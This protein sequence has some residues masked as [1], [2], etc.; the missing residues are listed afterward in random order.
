[1]RLYKKGYCGFYVDYWS[2]G[3]LLYTMLMGIV[4]FK[5]SNMKDLEELIKAGKYSFPSKISEEATNLINGLIQ[6]DPE[7]RYLVPEILQHKWLITEENENVNSENDEYNYF[8]V[9]NEE[10]SDDTLTSPSINNLNIENLFFGNKKNLRISFQDY[11]YIANDFYT[12][13][14]DEEAL[15]S[16]EQ[17][18]YPKKSILN[19]LEKQDLNHGTASYNLL[20]L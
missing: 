1:M 5:A 14:I 20:L 6:L 3:I 15:R 2:L 17:F 11:T 19:S 9:K 8:I 10:A 16:I 4:P 7:K 12:N 13:H 18:G